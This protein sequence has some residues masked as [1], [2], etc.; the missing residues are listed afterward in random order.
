MIPCKSCIIS[1]IEK[2]P[3]TVV[4]HRPSLTAATSMEGD[5]MADKPLSHVSR[6]TQSKSARP[7]GEIVK[8]IVAETI[9][10][11]MRHG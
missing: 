3:G 6:A 8:P 11:V 4:A 1:A 2:R 10:K 7:I 5:A 9:R